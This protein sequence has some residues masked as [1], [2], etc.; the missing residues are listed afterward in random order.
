MIST[1]FALSFLIRIG[2]FFPVV[3]LLLFV[4]YMRYE[5]CAGDTTCNNLPAAV[6]GGVLS[7]PADP[8]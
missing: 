1:H 6:G 8:G 3:S 7:P 4:N 2:M 5:F